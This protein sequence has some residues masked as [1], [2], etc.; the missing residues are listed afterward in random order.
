[1]TGENDNL[2]PC[3]FC[4]SVWIDQYEEGYTDDE[5]IVFYYCMNCGAMAD[6]RVWNK[7][8]NLE[9]RGENDEIS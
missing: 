7:R 6:S 3:P 5:E 2:L 9:I 4:G 8:V 1:M